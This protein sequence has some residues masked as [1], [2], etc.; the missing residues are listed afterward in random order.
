[1]SKAFAE[2]F[3]IPIF[4]KRGIID[5]NNKINPDAARAAGYQVTQKAPS[6]NTDSQGRLVSNLTGKP[7]TI[8]AAPTTTDIKTTSQKKETSNEK[9]IAKAKRIGRK[10]T[11]LTSPKGLAN[12]FKT[13]KKTLLGG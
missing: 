8:V 4:K 6:F 9:S 13:T 1:M 5:S 7:P 2:K 10:Y 3:V 12:N 11:I